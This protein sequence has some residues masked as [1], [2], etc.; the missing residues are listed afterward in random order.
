MVIDALWRALKAKLHKEA[1]VIF[2]T[3]GEVVLVESGSK[4]DSDCW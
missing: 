2:Y 4:S 3:S 1:E